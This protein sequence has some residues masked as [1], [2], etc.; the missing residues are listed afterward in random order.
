[1][2]ADGYF[3][4]LVLIGDVGR[5]RRKLRRVD[6]PDVGGWNA[7]AHVQQ[8][9]CQ[10]VPGFPIGPFHDIGNPMYGAIV[11]A[12]EFRPSRGQGFAV[13]LRVRHR[14]FPQTAVPGDPAQRLVE[15]GIFDP[16]GVCA[17]NISVHQAVPARVVAWPIG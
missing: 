7:I 9:I 3:D 12:I 11:Q 2:F 14:D 6:R 16:L 5:D 8:L 13:R 1:M 4:P 17:V 10:D 15:M